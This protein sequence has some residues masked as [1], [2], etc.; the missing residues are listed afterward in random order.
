MAAFTITTT[1]Q[2]IFHSGF[3][4]RTSPDQ[5]VCRFAPGV[6]SGNVF[7]AKNLTECS[8]DSATYITS[9]DIATWEFS[10]SQEVWACTDTDTVDIRISSWGS[11]T[12]AE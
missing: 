7:L 2:K 11:T 8:A 6:S 5:V 10:S 3:G 9:A 4:Q 12:E 1:P